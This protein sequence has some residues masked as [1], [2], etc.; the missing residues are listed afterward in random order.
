MIIGTVYN[1]LIL[2]KLLMIFSLNFI[3][4]EIG[5]IVKVEEKLTII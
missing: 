5:L 1:S 2:H 3:I 4:A